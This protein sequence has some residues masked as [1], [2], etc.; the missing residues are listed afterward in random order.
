M[1][2]LFISILAGVML[3]SCG[4][5][6]AEVD[7][8]SETRSNVRKPVTYHATVTSSFKVTQKE[9]TFL[10]DTQDSE[11]DS[12][13][14]CF[15]ETKKGAVHTFRLYENELYLT[16]QGRELGLTRQSG[17]PYSLTGIWVNNSDDG[18]MKIRL[19]MTINQAAQTIKI[20]AACSKKK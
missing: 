11:R 15:V 9:I 6:D 3:S 8:K 16:V 7:A 5:N 2:I 13:G 10:K 19:E 1:K 18:V 14:S 4:S 17:R 20:H 12:K